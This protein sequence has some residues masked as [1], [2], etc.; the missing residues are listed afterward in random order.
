MIKTS[1]RYFDILAAKKAYRKGINIVE[2]LRNQKN[3]DRNTS[4]IIEAA[5]DLQ[6]GTYIEYVEKNKTKHS[7]YA[8]E[9]AAIIDNHIRSTDSLLD[10]GTGELTT[11]SLLTQRLTNKPKNIFA[12][13][14]SWSRIHRGLVYAKNNMGVCYECLKPFVADIGEIPLLD[15]SVNITTSSH[16]LEPNGG[17]LTELLV[18]LFRVT[19][20]KL[21]LFEP[22]YEV[23]S[24]EGKKRMDRLGYIKDVDSTVEKLGGRL[25]EKIRIKT[26]GNPLSPTVCYLIY[27]P[28]TTTTQHVG[29]NNSDIFS[30]PGTNYPLKKID[31][32][33]FSNTTGLC[34]PI[35][36]SI[37]ILKSN[38]AILASSL[39]AD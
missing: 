8:S 21:I 37:P 39:S 34:F 27:P 26:L 28:K 12:F 13:D 31:G 10:I 17:R 33:Y 38:A 20:D 16:A 9:L 6:A 19:I 15:K 29:N 35:L 18:E 11:L 24:K 4:E 1:L 7:S 23:N 14:I 5:Y 32:F 3:V 36:K 2:V 25:V 30:V 22:C